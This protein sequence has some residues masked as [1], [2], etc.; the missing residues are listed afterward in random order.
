MKPQLT[1]AVH[2]D[3]DQDQDPDTDTAVAG[4]MRE[5]D[6]FTAEP[7]F[8]A[9]SNNW[10]VSGAHTVSGKPLLSNDMHLHHQVPGVW[11]EA[12]LT[13]GDFDVAGVTLP[14]LPF[15]I[16]GHNRRIAWGFTNLGPDVEDIFVETFNDKGEYLYHPPDPANPPHRPKTGRPPQQP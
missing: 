5:M 2:Q 3:D 9:G 10:V 12:Q 4:Y 13:A 1:P 8:R 6:P 15:V 14:G 7:S 11:Y 16:A